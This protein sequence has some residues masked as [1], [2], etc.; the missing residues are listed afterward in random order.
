MCRFVFFFCFVLF[1]LFIVFFRCIVLICVGD[2]AKA[3][4]IRRR[5]SFVVRLVCDNLHRCVKKVAAG[6]DLNDNGEQYNAENLTPIVV[7]FKRLSLE[8][9]LF[10]DLSCRIVDTRSLY[11]RNI[12]LSRAAAR[13]T[14]RVA[15]VRRRRPIR[16]TFS[17]RAVVCCR[18]LCRLLLRS[19]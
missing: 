19:I 2:E 1:C 14:A 13:R 12:G 16:R 15:G 5:P 4:S 11:R 3:V 9:S 10:D 6:A 7:V 17:P 18:R 8:T